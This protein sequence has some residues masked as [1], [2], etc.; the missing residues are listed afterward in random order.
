[1]EAL[2][3]TLFGGF[4]VTVQGEPIAAFE[5]NK[6]RALLAY[7]AV[8]AS[9]AGAR[10]HQRAVLAGLLWPDYPEEMARTNLRHVLRQLRQTLPETAGAAPLLLTTQQT[11]QINP[12]CPYTLDVARFTHLLAES[13]RCP[14]RELA[15]C[16]ACLARYQE[17]AEL[18][19]GDF[20]AGLSLY[21]SEP[22]DEWLVIQREGLHRQALELFFTLATYHAEQGDDEQAQQYVRRQLHLEPWREEAHRQLMRLLAASGQR[23]AALAQYTQCRKILADELSIEPDAETTALYEQI[24]SGKLDKKTRRQDDKVTSD[25]VTS[26]KVT[27][28]KVTSDKVTSDKVTVT[29]PV[30]LSPLHPVTLSSHQDWGNAPAVAFFYGRT[31]E[32]EQLQAWLGRDPRQAEAQQARLVAVLGMGGMGKTTLVAKAA[33]ATAEHFAFVF[34]FSLLNA[35]PVTDYLRTCLPFLARQQLAQLPPMLGEQVTLLLSYLR[36]QRCLLVL[37]NV[38]S[39]LE[40]GQAGHYR[41]GYEDYGQLIERIAQSEHQ[42]CLLLT[43]RERP[44]RLGQLEEDYPWVHTLPLE[45]LGVAAGE[46]LLKTRGLADETPLV[47]EVVQRYSGN[48]LALKLVARTI[49]ELFDG[50]VAAFLRDETPI[51]DDIRS[52]LDEQFQ[53]LT[54]LEREILCWLAI[55]RES[56]ALPAL[57][58]N[59]VRPPTR[60]DLLEA[61]RALQRRSLLEK[62]P[63]GFTLQNVVIEYVTEAIIAQVCAEIADDRWLN[64]VQNAPRLRAKG[65]RGEQLIDHFLL[66]HHALLKAQATTHVRQSQLR[67]IVQPVLNRLVAHVGQPALVARLEQLRLALQTLAAGRAA[68]APGYLGGNLLN[69]LRALEVD[70]TGRDFSHL[71]LW[72]A[73]LQGANLRQVNFTGADLAFSTFTYEFGHIFALALQPQR[74]LLAVG[75]GAGEIRLW[76]LSDLQPQRILTGHQNRVQALAFH[77]NGEILASASSDTTVRLWHVGRGEQLASLT[78]HRNGVLAV[79]FSPD[80][81]ILASS[82]RD[83]TIYLW[84]LSE[85]LHG[86]A[87]TVQPRQILR[88]H[89]N[90]VDAIAFHPHG[91]LLA[92]GSEDATIALWDVGALA[93]AHTNLDAPNDGPVAQTALRLVLRHHSDKVTALTFNAAG[94]LCASG[95]AGGVVQ[96]WDAADGRLLHRLT[97][98]RYWVRSLA[99]TPDGALLASG[100][101]DRTVRLWDVAKGEL[102]DTLYG[103]TSTIWAIGITSDGQ[104]LS[105]AGEDGTI[106]LWHLRGQGQQRALHTVQGY[107]PAVHTLAFSPDGNTLA[108]GDEYGTIHLWHTPP[109]K[110]PEYRTLLSHAGG[111]KAVVFS[112]TGRYLASAGDDGVLR[113]WDLLLAGAVTTLPC[114]GTLLECVAF[115]PNEQMVATGGNNRQL[116]LWDRQPLPHGRLVQA[117]QTHD[118]T[119]RS[120]VFSHQGDWLISSSRDGAICRWSLPALLANEEPRPIVKQ[121]GVEIWSVSLSPDSAV[122]AAACRDGAIRLWPVQAAATTPPVTV[123]SGHQTLVRAVA[124][125]PDQRTIASGSEDHT[126]RLWDIPSG[127]QRSLLQKHQQAVTAVAFRPDGKILASGGADGAVNLWDA[128]TGAHIATRQPPGPYAGLKITGVT[129]ITAAQK[130][131]LKALGAVEE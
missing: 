28:D 29:H 46:A 118:S 60:S 106:R 18:Y 12:A 21:D 79:A 58:Q 8:E 97:G 85:A 25:K 48:P 121:T 131:A 77:P 84:S 93:Q 114:D 100:S 98:H 65:G 32:L 51:F 91:R 59:L 104:V 78:G 16:P 126:V 44:H 19:R 36:Q 127:Q 86:S 116:Y 52:V 119:I 111:V 124:F 26:D 11:I 3:I 54:P 128:E 14:Q 64:P 27:S 125:S 115:A 130:A 69:L 43:S 33:R 103:H 74:T 72:Q 120:V 10:P 15:A 101:A 38:E 80:G 45:G 76:R 35:P 39:I 1:M 96:L 112:A 117:R 41:P 105:S 24:R 113:V 6:V 62:T 70:L 71:C 83:H 81:A 95:D 50:D 9:T 7:L 2:A 4:A 110:A 66:Q 17:A 67:Q 34:W 49:Q 20:L 90:W 94:T 88:H 61:L 31:Q 108:V 40:A 42:S 129:G 5:S 109:A 99:F 47:Q 73:N 30:T 56:I 57:T 53:R 75:T 92:S 22:F 55:E 102:V 63:A 122:L 82:S 87:G 23:S 37:D 123:L 107:L 89:T 13:R 68:D